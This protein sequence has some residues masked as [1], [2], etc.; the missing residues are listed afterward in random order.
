M[1]MDEET[2]ERLREYPDPNDLAQTLLENSEMDIND[3]R[4]LQLWHQAAIGEGYYSTL[5]K[6]LMK[7][8][9][10][11]L[12]REQR[13]KERAFQRTRK[14]HKGAWPPIPVI[15]LPEVEKVF[16]ESPSG[17]AWVPLTSEERES[18]LTPGGISFGSP[19]A[20]P[21]D[22][23]WDIEE[24]PPRMP[25]AWVNP[26]SAPAPMDAKPMK[27]SDLTFKEAVSVY[28]AM[29]FMLWQH[30]TVMNTHLIIIWEMLGIDEEEAVKRL[31]RYLHEA[32]KWLRVGTEP[33]RRF[34][35]EPRT[36]ADMHYVWVNENAPGRGF[37]SHVLM[38]VPSHLREDFEQ[39]S[40][41]CLIRHNGKRNFHPK[42]VRFKWSYERTHDG[43]VRLHWGWYRYLMK[44]LPAQVSFR[45]SPSSPKSALRDVIKPWRKR[46]G[47]LVPAS[48]KLAS[49]SHSI[50]KAAQAEIQ[51]QSPLMRGAEYHQLYGGHE[52]EERRLYDLS[53]TLSI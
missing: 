5:I 22:P 34:I 3:S 7:P 35:D 17:A 39:W 30:R 24:Y 38:N 40:R 10:K 29:S 26:F 49:V 4:V 13:Q 51:Y 44:Q 18:V 16:G 2:F 15:E 50:G 11:R 25:R 1:E 43:Q 36:G 52:F 46:P 21:T 28:A 47:K 53:L 31:G 33:R 37:H 48:V 45:H 23:D 41:A 6:S 42:A 14:F 32:Q 9:S 20:P 19:Y 12:T 27:S 8:Q